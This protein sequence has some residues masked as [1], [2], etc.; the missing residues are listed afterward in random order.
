M[1]VLVT[2]FD[3]TLY[4]EDSNVVTINENIAALE[5]FKNEKDIYGRNN[6]VVVSTAREPKSIMKYI[7]LFK[8]PCDYVI[9]YMGALIWDCAA[10]KYIY[11]NYFSSEDATKILA[12]IKPYSSEVELE[13]YSDV[14]NPTI[15]QHIGYIF[16]NENTLNSNVF[17]RMDADFGRP[18]EKVL[19]S[20]ELEDSIYFSRFFSNEWYFINNTKN[21]KLIALD[22]LI[23]N[24][25][26]KDKE[27]KNIYTIG[28]SMDDY[29]MISKYNGCRMALS[30]KDLADRYS[31]KIESVK[32]YIDRIIQKTIN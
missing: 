27:Q 18:L 1:K 13:I 14:P 22:Y 20:K 23:D 31:K 9:S 8:I 4:V 16:H 7:N 3:G 19:G 32:A 26:F 10:E 2:D 30:E 24:V 15:N 21:N 6:I 11:R 12:M 17:S 29:D 25:I 28:D 5:L